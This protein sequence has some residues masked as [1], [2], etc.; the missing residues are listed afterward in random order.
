MLNI[1]GGSP[2]GNSDDQER[3]TSAVF[4]VNKSGNSSSALHICSGVVAGKNVILTAA[5]CFDRPE[6]TVEQVTYATFKTELQSLNNNTD[7]IAVREIILHPDHV[8]SDPEQTNFD[9]A[10]LKLAA[11]VPETQLVAS[12]L[13]SND[14]L[15]PNTEITAIGYGPTGSNN[16]D[17]GSKRR[18]NSFIKDLINET[19][20]PG[21][22]LQNQMRVSDTTP[23]KRGACEGDSG[24]PGFLKNKAQVF[25]LVQGPHASVQGPNPTC[26]LGDFNFTLIAPYMTWIE[27]KLGYK[28]NVSGEPQSVSVASGWISSSSGS[29]AHDTP[30]EN[31]TICR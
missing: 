6:G 29:N 15:T 31:N 4:I 19:N 3:T 13:T 30:D 18:T 16:N 23:S 8:T 21:T 24:G 14:T 1:V 28:L 10:L 25:G 12:F 26:E 27:D 20:Y 11:N 22:P 2:S 9:I 17:A 7:L 5:S